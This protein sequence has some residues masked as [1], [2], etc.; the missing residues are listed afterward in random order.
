MLIN[1]LQSAE[2]FKNIY[3]PKG[4]LETTGESV[5]RRGL[6]PVWG[7][8]ALAPVRVPGNEN[9]MRNNSV[10]GGGAA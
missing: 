6:S 2:D 3:F 5:G 1:S 9:P 10:G 7:R 8:Y 4:Y